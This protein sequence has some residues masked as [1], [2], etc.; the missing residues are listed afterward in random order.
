MFQAPV[1]ILFSGAKWSGVK[2]PCI[3]HNIAVMVC[4]LCTAKCRDYICSPES[5]IPYQSLTSHMVW[6]LHCASPAA[7]FS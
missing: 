2:R 7:N 5:S 3:L 1:E 4:G 6:K